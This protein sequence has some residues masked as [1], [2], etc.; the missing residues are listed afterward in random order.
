M[1][2]GFGPQMTDVPSEV[3]IL[4]IN[5]EVRVKTESVTPG[6]MKNALCFLDTDISHYFVRSWDIIH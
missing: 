6:G 3:L 5:L 2:F 4:T 1:E